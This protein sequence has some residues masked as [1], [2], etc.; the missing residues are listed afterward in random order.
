MRIA[1]LAWESLHS[2]AIGGVAAHV[3]ELAVALHRRGHS[4][5]VF[6]RRQA[7]QSFY[8]HIDDVHYYRC[9]YPSHP[10]FIE[11]VNSNGG[12]DVL[13]DSLAESLAPKR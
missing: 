5:H 1:M 8:S 11:E 2:V 13:A 3:S 6:T 10:D 9:S 7:G 4:V 12:I